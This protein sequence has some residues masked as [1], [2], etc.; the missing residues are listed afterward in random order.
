MSVDQSEDARRNLGLHGMM[1]A[2]A[3]EIAGKNADI[4]AMKQMILGLLLLGVLA[5][6]AAGGASAERDNAE[7]E[8]DTAQALL[9]TIATDHMREC[10]YTDDGTVD[11]VVYRRVL[12]EAP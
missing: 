2:H 5:A 7:R 4:R 10:H 12:D 3:C 8:R 1:Q 6:G 11:G 9:H